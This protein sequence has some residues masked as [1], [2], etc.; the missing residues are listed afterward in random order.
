MFVMVQA[1]LGPALQL[2][3]SS[4]HD[5]SWHCGTLPPLSYY[6]AGHQQKRTT[7]TS[8]VWTPQQAVPMQCQAAYVRYVLCVNTPRVEGV[9]L[10]PC[11]APPP[12]DDD[13]QEALAMF[14]PGPDWSGPPMA[15]LLNKTD[16]LSEEQVQQLKEWYLGNCRA[17]KVLAASGK[18]F[19]GRVGDCS[20]C[21]QCERTA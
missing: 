5:T 21:L 4:H 1:V 8:P 7:E 6:K 3:D 16:L 13:P 10:L 15:V 12:S 20:M 14:Q 17:E 9:T 19:V 18:A 2:S 11:A